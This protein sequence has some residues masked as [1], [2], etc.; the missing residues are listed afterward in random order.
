MSV[1]GSASMAVLFSHHPFFC[2]FFGQ[3]TTGL[4][5]VPFAQSMHQCIFAMWLG[6]F[7]RGDGE[8]VW[9]CHQ[10]P[11]ISIQ[12]SLKKGSLLWGKDCLFPVFFLVL[13]SMKA[14]EASRDQNAIHGL[15]Q[16]VWSEWDR[17][18]FLL[19]SPKAIGQPMHGFIAVVHRILF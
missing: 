18:R 4:H 12:V 6:R 8:T 11:T 19:I 5:S 1:V 13:V 2:S 15:L 14:E 3:S 7:T 17:T 9:I 10:F 16:D